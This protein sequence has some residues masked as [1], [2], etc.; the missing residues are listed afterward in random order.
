M[1]SN[2]IIDKNNFSID[3][4][5]K[6]NQYE[7]GEMHLMFMKGHHLQEST[8]DMSGRVNKNLIA[9]QGNSQ[10]HHENTFYG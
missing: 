2:R 1:N 8:V 3:H 4:S 10:F 5:R 6:M 9:Y 7:Q